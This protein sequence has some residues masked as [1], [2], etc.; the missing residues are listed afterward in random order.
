MVARQADKPR[1]SWF[2]LFYDLV[3]V[4]AIL[5]GSHVFVSAPSWSTG[6]WLAVTM[7]ILFTV[8]LTTTL[9]FNAIRDDWTLRRLLALVQMLAVVVASL[10][11]SREDGL[12]DRIGFVALAAA[13]GSASALYAVGKDRVD[14]VRR[15]TGILA[16]TLASAALI[17]LV[18]AA[19]PQVDGPAYASPSTYALAVGVIVAVVPVFVVQ[20]GPKFTAKSLDRDHLGERLG[21]FVIIAL[22]ES[23]ADLVLT[24][25]T[26]DTLP[27]PVFLGL[28]FVVIY[29]LWAIYFQSVLPDGVPSGIARLRAWV[30]C[31]YLL[32]FGL[33][34]TAGAFASLTVL[35]LNDAQAAG[36]SY[37]VP[38]PLLYVMVGFTLLSVL[39]GPVHR[40][41]TMTHALAST[42][43]LVLAITGGL[44][45]PDHQMT[46]GLIAAAVVV[47]DAAAT[48]WLSRRPR[49]S[50][51]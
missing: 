22:G 38:L 49:S 15:E 23:F 50:H 30:A 21:Q 24:L 9:S 8:W 31:H 20:L 42:T 26:L 5:H 4:A 19:L 34:G 17:F 10:S 32:I 25:G 2:E 44:L 1:V 29:C 40:R 12:S 37:R 45:Y 7:L 18:G 14:S 3:L 35:P 11:V 36:V 41:F 48:S 16:V 28:V 6:T 43:L 46:M 27:N 51:A 39:A 33:I 47:A 13:F